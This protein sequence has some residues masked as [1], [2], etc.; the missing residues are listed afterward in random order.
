MLAVET[1]IAPLDLAPHCDLAE[2]LEEITAY[3]AE[4]AREREDEQLSN[5]LKNRLNRT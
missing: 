2:V 5:E 1:S 3:L 4:R